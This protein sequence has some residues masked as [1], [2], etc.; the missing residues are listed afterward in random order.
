MVYLLV[1]CLFRCDLW[2]QQFEWVIIAGV[3]PSY[4]CVEWG[5]EGQWQHRSM[6]VMVNPLLFL[7]DRTPHSERSLTVSP[8]ALSFSLL[9]TD[10]LLRVTCGAY[11]PNLLCVGSILSLFSS[12]SPFLAVGQLRFSTPHNS[13]TVDSLK[14]ST[15]HQMRLATGEDKRQDRRVGIALGCSE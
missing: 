2:P 1:V 14:Q 11:L 7:L 8:L 4:M 15:F 13:E 9:R 12:I 3:I 5:I 10:I 6:W